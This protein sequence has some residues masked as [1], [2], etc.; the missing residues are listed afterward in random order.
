MIAT[1]VAFMILFSLTVP[2]C[3]ANRS[4]LERVH[5]KLTQYFY[6]PFYSESQYYETYQK[7]MENS[8]ELL[9]DADASEDDFDQQYERLKEVYAKITLDS[10]DYT[11]ITY[12][13]DDYKKLNPDLFTEDS[14]QALSDVNDKIYDQIDSPTLYKR[15]E[16]NKTEY[17]EQSIKKL[18][19]PIA[20]DFKIAFN[21][22]KLKEIK[23]ENF[24]K[25][26]LEGLLV[27]C[28][29]CAQ[30]SVY[31]SV[32]GWSAYQSK[33]KEI[34]TILEEDDKAPVNFYKLSQELLK[35][36]HALTSSYFNL[37]PAKDEHKLLQ[38]LNKYDY[39]EASWEAYEKRVQEL[40]NYIQ[41]PIFIYVKYLEDKNSVDDYVNQIIGEKVKTV[42]NARE[43]LVPQELI[44]KLSAL[45]NT[46]HHTTAIDGLNSKLQALLDNVDRGYQILRNDN[47]SKTEIENAILNIEN[48]AEDLRLAEIYMV[49][50]QNDQT[51]NDVQTI[52]LTIAFTV[53]SFILSLG[54]AFVLYNRQ[55]GRTQ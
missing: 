36:Y 13:Y 35:S 25:T 9:D 29:I 50:E 38:T 32:S 55:T 53:V 15:L 14:M 31:S 26:D 24:T 30:E 54:F 4:D 44:N 27:Y 48:A 47:S 23:E 33:A 5:E 20:A 17:Y 10:F 8:K 42:S 41:E 18:I 22:L 3:A 16:R 11:S 28:N 45:C 39:T 6:L 19:D 12:L 51:K 49:K 34:R 40:S 1:L 37:N 7:E 52:R 2:V 21:N 43:Q 46:Y